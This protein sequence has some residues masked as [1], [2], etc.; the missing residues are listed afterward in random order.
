MKGLAGI[1]LIVLG[2]ALGLYVGFYVCLFG[3]IVTVIE[4]VALVVNGGS[5][6]ASELAFGLVKIFGAGVAGA[7]SALVFL[8]PGKAMIID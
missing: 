3:G 1:I 6:V 2:L 7:I 4:Q 5:V 8:I